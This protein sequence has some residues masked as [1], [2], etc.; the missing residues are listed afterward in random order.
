MRAFNKAIDVLGYLF[1]IL[2]LVVVLLQIVF[3][4]LLNIGVPWTEELSRLSFIYLSFVGAA[5]S[6]RE[7]SLIK[8]D[9]I[10]DKA[11][12][13]A[14]TILTVVIN[15]FVSIF[16]VMMFYGSLNMIGLVWP[17]YFATMQWLSNGWMYFATASGFGL[18]IFYT[19]VS[20]LAWRR[21]RMS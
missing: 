16:I 12:G 14:L 2:M 19:L 18:M 21:R 1:F 17:T 7:K 13:A 4:F 8:V 20:L 9:T 5:I 11:R 15:V 6:F 10:I 3:R